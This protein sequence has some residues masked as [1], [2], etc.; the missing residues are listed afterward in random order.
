MA[1]GQVLSLS[2]YYCATCYF[3]LFGDLRALHTL[4]L[5]PHPHLIPVAASLCPI[6][7]ALLLCLDPGLGLELPVREREAASRRPHLV[8]ARCLHGQAC[9]ACRALQLGNELVRLA[10]RS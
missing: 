8:A 2:V 6:S 7:S 3:I 4:T 10:R 5:P 1:N 9:R